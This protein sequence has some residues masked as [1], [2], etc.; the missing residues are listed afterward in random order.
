MW[1]NVIHP[2]KEGSTDTRYHTAEPKAHDAE[3]RQKKGCLEHDSVDGKHPEQADP[4]RTGDEC[5]PGAGGI[6]RV[7]ANGFDGKF[8]GLCILPQQKKD[9]PKRKKKNSV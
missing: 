7:S 8:Y 1:W 2:Q 9:I 5:L 6:W 4:R 3:R